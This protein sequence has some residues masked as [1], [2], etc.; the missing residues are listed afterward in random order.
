MALT[1]VGLMNCQFYSL[2]KKRTTLHLISNLL[3]L[4]KPLQ[5]CALSPTCNLF[6]LAY[7]LQ[8]TFALQAA[9]SPLFFK[10]ATLL[11]LYDLQNT[12]STLR[13]S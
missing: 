11:K 7:A 3:S 4:V 1:F 5:P 9:T 13:H 2:L 10:L 8:A 12:S 6:N